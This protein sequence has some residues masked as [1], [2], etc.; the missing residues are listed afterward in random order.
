MW[1]VCRSPGDAS[2][3]RSQLLFYFISFDARQRQ[4]DLRFA[5]I[6]R[7]NKGRREEP[8][9][10]KRKKEEQQTDA[11]DELTMPVRIRSTQTG[12]LSRARELRPEN[13]EPIPAE[14][15]YFSRNSCTMQPGAI[16][17][18]AVSCRSG[19]CSA[20]MCFQLHSI[21][22]HSCFGEIH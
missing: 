10:R 17:V 4:R 2:V 6:E 7:G 5:S 12:R 1:Y 8:Q 9:Q 16:P 20:R 15:D 14:F 22:A 19:G 18:S 3:K 21:P 11:A 13:A